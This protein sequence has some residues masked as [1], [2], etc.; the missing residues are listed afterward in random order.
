MIRFSL[1]HTDGSMPRTVYYKRLV[2]ALTTLPGYQET[3]TGCDFVFPEEDTSLETN[4]PRYARPETAYIRGVHDRDRHDRYLNLLALTTSPLCII[5]MHPFI[6]V[7]VRMMNNPNVIVA[8][9]NLRTWERLLAPRS[10]S[11]PA[12]PVT[13]GQYKPELK[14]VMAGF[15]GVDSHP[16]RRE[17]TKLHNGTTIVAE[18]VDRTNHFGRLDADKKL[19]DPAYVDLMEASIFAL[20][21]RGDAEFSYR[22]LEAMSFGC[23]PV[24][25]SDGLVLPFDRLVPWA[26]FSLHMPESRISELPAFL[27]RMSPE[28]VAVMQSRLGQ[29]YQHYFSSVQHV[30]AALVEEV[31]KS[32]QLS[33]RV[34]VKTTPQHLV[35]SLTAKMKVDLPETTPIPTTGRNGAAWDVARAIKRRIVRVLGAA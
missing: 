10:I 2:E 24:I 26:D 33:D 25:L 4:W 21:P 30:A 3:P 7:P 5:N 27:A 35:T 12:L 14:R 1:D 31:G 18:L 29:A 28:R 11:M 19:V 6:R 13:V 17:L 32:L 23:I 22:L 8:D 15:R 9:I 34:D 16:C 20:V